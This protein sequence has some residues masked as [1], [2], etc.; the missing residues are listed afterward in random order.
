MKRRIFIRYFADKNDEIPKDSN[1]IVDADNKLASRYIND[2]QCGANVSDWLE[3]YPN[4]KVDF[5]IL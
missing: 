3:R 2:Y 1:P 4:G 5:V